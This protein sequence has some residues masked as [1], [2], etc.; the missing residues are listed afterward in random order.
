MADKKKLGAYICKG[1]G[2][3]ERLDIDELAKIAK[4]DGKVAIAKQHDF[5]CNSDG[6]KMIQADIDAGEVSH[7]VIAACSR[8]AKTDAFRFDNVAIART[9]LR[10]GVIW[11][12]PDTEDA[13]ETTQ[14]MAEDY[15]RMGCAEVKFMTLPS[16]SGEQGRVDHVLVVGGGFTGLTAALEI[17]KAG[18]LATIVEKTGALGGTAAQLYKR[19]PVRS[20]FADPQDNGIADLIQQIESNDKITVHLNATVSKTEG[21]PGRFNADISPDIGTKTFGSIIQASGFTPYD[22][23]QLPEFSYGKTPDVVDQLGLEALAKEANG[24][25]IKRPSDGKEVKNVVFVQCAGQR[26]EKEGHLSYCSGHCCMTSVKQAM[27]FKD[28]NPTVDAMVIYTELRMPGAA[29]EDFYR[30]GQDKGV[31]FTKGIVSEVVSEAGKVSVKFKDLIL[32]EE[33]DLESDL[34]VLATG[35]VA[36]SG[37]DSEILL[38]EEDEK[39]E[40]KAEEKTEEKTIIPIV[41]AESILNLEYRQGPDLPQLVN[42]FTDSHFICFPYETRRTGIYAAGPVR[43]PMDMA[44]A[45]E[46][47]TGAALKAIQALENAGIGRAAH[48]RSGDLSF[49][50][51][52]KEGCTQCK[53]CTV[54]C[55]FGAINEDEKGYPQFNEARCRRCGTCMGACPVRVIS[56]ENYSVE[57]VGQA[58]KSVDMPDEFDEKPRLLVLACE[59]DAYPALDMAGMTR[60][61]YSAFVRIIPVRCLGSVNTIWISDALNSGYDGIILMGCQKGDDYQCHFVKGSEMAHYRMSKIGDTLQQLQLETERV[62]TYEIAI[63]DMER[64][65]KIINDMAATIEKIGMNPFKF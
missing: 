18:Y 14:E 53:R 29:G 12:R 8:R 46:D 11:V 15:I 19:T 16:A 52:R 33:V 60:R 31:T 38:T 56:F 6:V 32:N 2:I 62:Q 25:A 5:L 3:S 40:E 57:T 37:I 28:A 49:P 4:S 9:N 47:A 21:A 34:V 7:I 24:G 54:E 51:F 45:T 17:A 42:G 41:P 35:M 61:E 30:N 20:P 65:P 63:T 27:Y 23:T 36:N 1:C 50:I 22:A 48:P 13:K 39:T 26:S 55:P 59:N 43:R 64:V 44:Q 10:E 58:I